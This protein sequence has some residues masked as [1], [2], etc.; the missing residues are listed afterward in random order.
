M[1]FCCGKPAVRGW[2]LNE[3]LKKLNEK[4]VHV[5]V[6]L[7]SCYAGG[8]WRADSLSRT[9]A[10]W[11]KILNAPADEEAITETTTE[12]TSRDG[13]LEESWSINPKGFTLMAAC[14]HDEGAAERIFN[15]KNYGA[16]THGLLASLRHSISA[17]EVMTYRTL[18][19]RID[20][21][22]NEQTPLV[23]GRDRLIFFGDRERFVP[24]PVIV[25]VEGE[26]INIPIGKAH[27]VRVGTTFTTYPPTQHTTFSADHVDLFEC[28][29]R[30][31]PTQ[32][33]YI[34][35][36]HNRFVPCRWKLEG[37][38]PQ[39]I[40]QSSLGDKFE[41]ALRAALENQVFGDIRTVEIDNSSD[42]GDEYFW[43]KK[44]ED[45][46][47]EIYGPR[48][49]IGYNGPV[50]GLDLKG[51][52]IELA[53][54]CAIALSHLA[55]FSQIL[56]LRGKASKDIAP[57]ELTINPEYDGRPL[58]SGQQFEFVLKN[59]SAN[60]C[61]YVTTFILSPAF[62]VR[63]LYPEH[64]SPLSIDPGCTLSFNFDIKVPD[65]LHPFK[66]PHRDIVRT[67]V[68][69]V[70]RVS[71]KS[72][73]LPDIWEAEQLECM[74]PRTDLGRDGSF[75]C[76]GPTWWIRDTVIWTQIQCTR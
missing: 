76:S 59:T 52:D 42:S 63:Q 75:T 27:G 1:D 71:W 4:E 60:A 11:N 25:R 7:D 64:D 29:S 66:A 18:R 17:K 6:T 50:R 8:S 9:P 39:L 35:W 38:A 57:F 40:I 62:H 47:L 65:G 46:D 22:L 54:K 67:I 51:D 43:L 20:L 10:F 32:L 19:D 26:N 56:G 28:I 69:T 16:F 37:D 5:I 24:Q 68:T 14:K 12:S 23:F 44:R 61:L 48:N 41:K 70:K 15:G 2:Q 45:N 74:R 21:L 55:R 31:Q 49:L 33:Q 3:W 34:Q 53:A 13:D 72:L 58:P 73:E 30:C 36:H